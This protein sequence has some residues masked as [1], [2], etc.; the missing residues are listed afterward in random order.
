MKSFYIVLC[1]FTTMFLAINSNHIYIE[2]FANDTIQICE[3]IDTYGPHASTQEQAR[4]IRD[5]WNKNRKFIQITVNHTEIEAIDNAVDEL[6]VF[7]EQGDRADLER[8]K[9]LA[10]NVFE[11]LSLSERLTLT[12]IL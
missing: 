9:L 5:R 11:E 4:E 10:I 7:A 6:L 2:R 3:Q 1:L 12:N 8:A